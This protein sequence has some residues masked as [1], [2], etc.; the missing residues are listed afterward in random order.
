MCTKTL[1]PVYTHLYTCTQTH[2]FTHK[3]THT[4]LYTCTQTHTR[5]FSH[6]S[7][8]LSPHPSPVPVYLMKSCNYYC[9]PVPATHWHAPWDVL[10]REVSSDRKLL[11]SQTNAILHPH[12]GPQLAGLSDM[13]TNL[14]RLAR[15]GTNRELFNI[16]FSTFWLSSTVSFGANLAHLGPNLTPVVAS[17]SLTSCLSGN[18]RVQGKSLVAIY[19]CTSRRIELFIKL[20]LFYTLQFS[21]LNE[22]IS[23]RVAEH[24]KV[25]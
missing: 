19:L 20:T 3:D 23:S 22:N 14:A 25:D 15:N 1:T 16:N 17:L 6:L 5:H 2:V 18:S 7:L 8:Y 24:P 9:P 11:D 13:G 21:N 10:S 12:A 4:G